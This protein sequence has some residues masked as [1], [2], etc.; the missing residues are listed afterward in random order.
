M[1]TLIQ[2]VIFGFENVT[3]LTDQVKWELLKY[4][5]RKFVIKFCKKLARNFRTLQR[6]LETKIKNLEQNITN[7]DKFNEYK[8][9]KDELEH[10]Y[11][12]LASGI[13]IRSKRD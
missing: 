11:D 1:K 4:K 5:I 9:T 3:Y 8:S 10:F 13:K 2:K 6:D 7:E 12:N